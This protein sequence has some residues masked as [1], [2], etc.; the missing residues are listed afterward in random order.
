[1]SAKVEDEKEKEMEY[2]DARRLQNNIER[3]LIHENY[4]FLNL[5]SKIEESNNPGVEADNSTNIDT[6]EDT[7]TPPP[8]PAVKPHENL[9][10]II[11]KRADIYGNQIKMFC[12][13]QYPDTLV[14]ESTVPLKNNQNARY[15]RLND[16][17]KENFVKKI[18]DFCK[19]IQARTKISR[20]NGKLI[21][22]VF[23]TIQDQEMFNQKDVI[24]TVTLVIE[25]GEKMSRFLLKTF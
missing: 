22:G 5:S 20:Q 4:K 17:Q 12:T 18:Y 1:M 14:I 9:F 11:I 21:I 7:A 6:S 25:K 8:Q 19:S 3:W 2:L 10:T 24:D 23:V 15:L 13:R 16:T